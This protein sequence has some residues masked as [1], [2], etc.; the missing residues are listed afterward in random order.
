MSESSVIPKVWFNKF[1]GDLANQITKGTTPTTLGHS[2]R[3]AGIPFIRI[4]NIDGYGINLSSVNSFIDEKA[5][6]DLMRSQLQVNDVLFTIAGTIGKTALV[7]E[8]DVPSN[9]NQAIGIIRGVSDYFDPKFL[10]YQLAEAADSISKTKGRGGAMSN[11]SLGDLKALNVVLPPLAEQK[12]IASRLDDLLTRIDSLKTRLDA[13]PQ[14]LKRFRQS[15]LAAAVSGRLTEGWRGKNDHIVSWEKKI[16]GDVI[17]IQNGCAFKSGWFV[18]SGKYQVIKLANVK[19]DFLKIDVASSYLPEEIAQDY[20]KYKP[21]VGDILITMTGT[22]YKKDY[23][24]VCMIKKDKEILVNQRVGRIIPNHNVIDSKYLMVY[25]RSEYY[26]NE[27]FR[28]ETGGVNQGNVGSNH[29]LSCPFI[30]PPMIE[31]KE[32]ARRVEQ[33]FAFADQIE[34]RV[35]EARAKAEHMTPSVLARA[36]RG[37]LTADWREQHPELISGEN[38]AKAL[39][40]KIR[41][42]KE[43]LKPAKK[44]RTRSTDR[45]KD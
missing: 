13:I 32:I 45:K 40:E 21:D 7:R 38:S 15:V 41:A 44:T 36:F 6:A 10:R 2:Y 1:L 5:H 25:L 34:N 28:G 42:Q 20:L 29:I 26:R 31:Q 33:L 8:E 43:S 17:T 18:K 39:L 30:S 23:G 24:Y 14:I 11:I 37:E 4:E 27:F 22:R 12:E 9:T 19:D 3:E 35:K 16:L